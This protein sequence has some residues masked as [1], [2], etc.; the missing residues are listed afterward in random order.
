M[1]KVGRPPKNG[2]QPMWVLE[3][4]TLALFAYERAREQ[5]EKHCVAVSEAVKYIRQ[6]APRMRVSETEVKRIVA[7]WRPKGSIKCLRVNEPGPSGNI[8]SAPV[9]RNGVVSFINCRVL[10]TASHGPRPI[11]R[12]ANAASKRTDKRDLFD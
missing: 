1:N 10:Y 12:R 9:L 5:G 3:R 11:Y 2:Q 8:V 6:T 4:I 7:Y